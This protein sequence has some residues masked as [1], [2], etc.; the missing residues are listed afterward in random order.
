MTADLT[1]GERKIAAASRAAAA[2][3]W[4]TLLTGAPVSTFPVDRPSAGRSA[5]A[6]LAATV[7]VEPALATRLTAVSRGDGEALHVILLAAT[8]AL[9]REYSGSADVLVARPPAG[10]ALARLVPVRHRFADDDTFR[11]LLGALRT[12][13]PEA[14]AHQDFPIELIGEAAVAV[15]VGGE[16]VVLTA[17]VVAHF[18]PGA[19]PVLDVHADPARYTASS[20]RR[21]GEQLLRLLAAALTAPDTPLVSLDLLGADDRALIAATNDTGRE[22]PSD[23]TL[24]ELFSRTV[25]ARPDAVAVAVGLTFAELDGAANRLAHRLRER[26]VGRESV[27]AVAAERSPEMLIAILAVLKAGGAYLPID[28][29]LPAT[30]IEYVL[31]DSEAVLV[32]ATAGVGLPAGVA[33]LDLTGAAAPGP[34]VAPLAPGDPGDAAYVIYTSG[35]TGRPKGVVVEHRSVVNRLHWMQRAYP[36]GPG[37]VILQKTPI[38]FDV[39]VWELFWWLI[40]GASVCLL[41]PGGE[42]EP[43]AIV[44]AVQQHGV[45]VLHFVPTM[46]GAFLGY[47]TDGSRLSSLRRVFASGEALGAHHVRRFHEL[48]DAE[49]VNLY[50]PTEATVDVSHHVTAPGEEVV[51]IGRPIDN[52]GLHVLDEH[53]RERPVGMPGELHLTG[54]GLARGYLNRPELTAER[55]P[56]VGG[57][58]AYRTGDLVRR[59][60]DGA[61]EYLGRNDFQVK[62]RGY[63]IEL[64]EIEQ[65]LRECPG[66]TDAAVVVRTNAD[67]QPH[68][69]GYVVAASAGEDGLRAALADD[70]PGY[71]VPERIVVLESFPFSPNGKLDRAG[72]PEPLAAASARVA[73][74]TEEERVLAGIWAEVL[75]LDEVGVTD[76]FFA[77]GGTSIHFV[78]VLARARRH[79]LDFTFQQLF[80]YPTVEALVAHAHE[81]ADGDVAPTEF[82]PFALITAEDRA[83]LPDG[84]EDAYPMSMLQSGLIYQSEIMRG[85]TSYHDII[86]Y[87][88][89]SSV[90]TGVFREAVRVLVAQNPILRTSYHLSGYSDYLQLVHRETG[91]LPLVVEDLRDVAN[92]DAWYE[93]WF[94]EEQNRPFTWEEPGLVRLHVHVLSDDLYRYSYSQHNSALDGWSINQLHTRLFEIYYALRDTGAYT[95]TPVANHLRNFIGLERHALGSAAHHR[96]WQQELADRPDTV[97]P[98]L[99]EPDPA[100]ELDVVFEDIPLPAGLSDRVLA[101]ADRLGV[102]VKSVL[103]ASHVRV[104]A[105]LCGVADVL[106]GYEHAGRPEL[107]DADRAL[108]VF[109]NSMPFRMQPAPGSWADLVRQ[110][111]DTEARTLPYRR[112]PMAKVKQDFRTTEPLFETVFNFTHFYS[113]KALKE[114]PE[115]ALLDV[116]AAAIT[117]FPLRTEYSR[118][119]YTDEVQL[120]LHYHT[121]VFDA[122][123]IRRIGGYFVRVLEAMTATPEAD[124]ETTVLLGAEELALVEAF[125]A[126][127]GLTVR[128]AHGLPVP[129]GTPGVLPD[130]RRGR[131][132]PDGALEVV[133]PVVAAEPAPPAGA[134]PVASGAALRK[135][136]EVWADVLELDAETI[137]TDDDFFEIGGS[138]LAAMRVVLLLD[139]LVT[140][141]EVMRCSQLG[142]LAEAVDRV[143]AAETGL[144][145]PLSAVA[146]PVAHLVCVPYAGGNAVHFKPVADAMPAVHPGVAVHA[147]E[148]PGHAPGSTVDDLRPFAAIAARVADEIIAS[149]SGPVV[150]WGHCVG[151]ALAI[152]V[153]RLLRDR[154]RAPAHLFLAAKLLPQPAEIRETLANAEVLSF[155]DVRGLLAEWTGSDSYGDLGPEFEQ[156]LTRA[157]RH[158]SLTANGFLLAADAPPL[159][160]PATVVVAADDPVTEGFAE[161]HVEWGRR[162]AGAGLHVLPDGGHYFT[163]TRPADIAALVAAKVEP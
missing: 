40:E 101:L 94:A 58:R 59:R 7:P 74:R 1:T 51:P 44:S 22:F 28:P 136:R 141:R 9:L 142:E 111:Y 90:D 33:R 103:L 27:V 81:V 16:Q 96:F 45:T 10:E 56:V 31:A 121:A 118:H 148:L 67:G 82:E 129:V 107:P 143:S 133:T 86:S 149:L 73:P 63:R 95:G 112:Y 77:L 72:L 19:E 122:E 137:R 36:I 47:L 35:S 106:T 131:R 50:G 3:F 66:V 30:R 15:A 25:A 140:L 98:R 119:F 49:L 83:K 4:T 132:L 116:R 100:R 150:V 69:Y 21:I 126:V 64:G 46:L 80:R 42:R 97:V 39:S 53:G 130:G 17:D 162:V 5:A 84:V 87:L 6:R 43:E 92:Q 151:S 156:L 76:G 24:P 146:T 125:A 153:S 13:V 52:T 113:L 26:G 8:L 158:D 2:G 78:S 54:A 152:E 71:M 102:P 89:R 105:L 114:L 154:G 108:G 138:S 34:A 115:F 93:R 41:E 123:H 14:L 70:L 135:V 62:I 29:A 163:R 55:F 48:L 91:E 99:R 18:R 124:H 155:D 20:A 32:L 61:L 104:H 65:R 23:V 159:D 79:G 161:N 127:D 12:S 68:L 117:E 11:S 85:N 109:L 75:G 37:D 134:E 110:A 139:G 160:V 38:S 88:I 128:D 157:F 60:P 144:L 120:S 57:Q 147:V 145:V